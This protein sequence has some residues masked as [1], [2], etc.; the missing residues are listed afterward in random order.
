MAE[1]STVTPSRPMLSNDIMSRRPPYDLWIESTGVPIHRGYYIEDARTVEVGPWAERE[2]NAAFLQLAGCEG[3]TEA[4]I[5][6]IP[7]G[8]TLPPLRFAFDEIVYV[9]DGRGTTTVWSDHS[10]K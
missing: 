7:A 5:T 9:V 4:R 10:Q 3:V 1:A 2:C 6:E 8:A